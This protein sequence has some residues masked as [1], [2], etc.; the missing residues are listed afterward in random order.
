MYF[1]KI[2]HIHVC[3]AVGFSVVMATTFKYFGIKSILIPFN[4][5]IRSTR[6]RAKIEK[7]TFVCVL[8]PFYS[9]NYPITN[10]IDFIALKQ[11]N[12]D[13]M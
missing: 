3:S 12:M 6:S 9:N 5:D 4:L 2:N 10:T 8:Q 7:L 11:K 1:G 13:S